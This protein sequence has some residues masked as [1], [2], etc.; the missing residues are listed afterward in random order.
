MSLPSSSFLSPTHLP[1]LLHLLIELPASL[2]FYFSPSSQLPRST[3]SAHALIRQY[4]ILLLSTNL[5]A[6]IFLLHPPPTDSVAEL[7]R[8]NVA[9]A[10]AVYHVAPVVR[11]V[12]R[13]IG[14]AGRGEGRRGGWRGLG[15]PW[16]HL[17]GHSGCLV[18]LDRLFFEVWVREVVRVWTGGEGKG[19]RVSGFAG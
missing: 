11:A 9:G 18:A 16:V 1:F 17:V 19:W 4:A 5:I 13:I 2:S 8:G 7:L 6:L 10:L 3:P 15:G 12:S 14:G